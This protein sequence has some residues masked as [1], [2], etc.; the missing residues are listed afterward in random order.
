M[1]VVFKFA[2]KFCFS[3]KLHISLNF[4]NFLILLVCK[5]MTEVIQD[6]RRGSTTTAQQQPNPTPVPLPSTAHLPPVTTTTGSNST[7][8]YL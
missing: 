5:E 4:G 3:F 6:S 8:K 2:R 7:C 1:F